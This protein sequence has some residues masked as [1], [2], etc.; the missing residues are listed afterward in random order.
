MKK[1]ILAALILISIKTYSQEFKYW[2]YDVVNNTLNLE[3]SYDTMRP[4]NNNITV[5]NKTAY[6]WTGRVAVQYKKNGFTEWSNAAILSLNIQPWGYVYF[7]DI[8]YACNSS[9][10]YRYRVVWL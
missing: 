9:L 8:F 1:L 6:W 2:D 5:Y 3:L 4:C 10:I 7:N